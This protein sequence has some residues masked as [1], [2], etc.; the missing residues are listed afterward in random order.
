MA[1]RLARAKATVTVGAD[2]SELQGV[3]VTVRNETV[4]VKLGADTILERDGV[5]KVVPLARR[6]WQIEFHAPTSETDQLTIVDE[7][8]ACC[9]RR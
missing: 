2:G 6:T 7:R 5:A 9:G 8:R 4:T 3:S 1:A